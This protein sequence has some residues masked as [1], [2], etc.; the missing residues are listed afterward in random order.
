MKKKTIDTKD[1][2]QG[3]RSAMK[4]R[5]PYD[6]PAVFSEDI[7]GITGAACSQ[8][9]ECTPVGSPSPN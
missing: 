7:L 6:E 9:A 3:S 4:D 1:R 8:D 5:R 2:L